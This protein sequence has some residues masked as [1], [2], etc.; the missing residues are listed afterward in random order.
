MK[1]SMSMEEMVTLK[2]PKKD[3]HALLRIFEDIQFLE[4]AEKNHQEMKKGKF[5]TLGEF[6]KKH[7]L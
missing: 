6:R 4:K 1:Q 7:H 2:I 3:V 5:I